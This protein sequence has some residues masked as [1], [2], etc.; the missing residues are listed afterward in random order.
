MFGRI[1][2]YRFKRAVVVSI[3]SG[4][5]IVGAAVAP[6]LRFVNGSLL[7]LLVPGVVASWRRQSIV[8]L[9]LLCLLGFG[10][11]LWR[12]SVYADQLA[13]YTKL[14]SQKVT[15]TGVA[16]D[17]A[18]Y[19]SREQLS[20]T[21]TNVRLQAPYNAPLLG[22]V[23]VS[24]FGASGIRRGD[25]VQ[26]AGKLQPT[27][28]GN[29]ATIS[30]GLLQVSHSPPGVLE[31]L[32]R[33]FVAGLQS[34]L[35]EPLASFGLG[36]LVGQKNT[37]PQAASQ[38]LLMAG[39]THIIAV[40]GY[41]LTIILQVVRR[42]LGKSS[43]FQT[44]AG[45][46]LLSLVFLAL[47]GS[48]PSLTRAALI[49]ALSLTA[50]YYGREIKPAVLLLLAAAI[51]VV[52]NPLFARGNISW[53]LSFLA[54]AGVL[55]LGP[56]L[57][58]RLF[59]AREPLLLL[60]VLVESVCAEAMTVPYVLH[61]FGQMSLVSLLANILVV[62][63]VPLGML[64]TLIAGIAGM[65][66]APFAGWFAWPARL[67][68]TYMLDVAT[69][70]SRIPYAFIQNRSFSTVMMLGCYVVV[71]GLAGI[72]WHWG[73]RNGKITP[74]DSETESEARHERSLQM[75]HD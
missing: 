3:T 1:V 49:S 39:L 75:V 10:T 29:Q 23:S 56:L 57:T 5:V 18:T 65:I 74:I 41:N 54:F 13:I 37:L 14:F 53:C 67:L 42:L 32:R 33:R 62:A 20:M 72:L 61:I 15:I 30:F 44:A 27:L 46:A 63:L 16:S 66:A 25:V 40:S 26:A 19:G 45:C 17:D 12:G 51:T 73:R 50:W 36:L 22:A 71:A 8:T 48:S 31:S 9:L 70:L 6:H 64:L 11:G 59:G 52:M 60:A 2:A 24:G 69:L 55:L 43:K 4:A 34:A 38:A 21:L 58:R 7:L 68:L 47:A 35:P 28:G